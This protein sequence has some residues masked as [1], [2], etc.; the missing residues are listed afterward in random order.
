M[1]QLS[2]FNGYKQTL[3]GLGKYQAFKTLSEKRITKCVREALRRRFGFAVVTVSCA[4]KF[5]GREW[6]GEYTLA[7][8]PLG[9]RITP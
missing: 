2:V 3:S 6:K 9:Y 1:P 8:K 4:A 5:D 7:G